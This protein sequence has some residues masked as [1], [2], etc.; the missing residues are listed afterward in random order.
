[1]KLFAHNLKEDIAKKADN[2][3]LTNVQTA[4]RN[5][6]SYAHLKDL[7]SKVVPPIAKFEE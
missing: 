5:C 3:E 4:L 6:C 1:V 2:V 7:Y